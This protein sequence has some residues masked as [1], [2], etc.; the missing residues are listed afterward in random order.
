MIDLKPS[1]ERIEALVAQGTPASLTYAALECRLALERVCYDR[2]RQAHD[3]IAHDDLNGWSPGAIVKQL[4][5]DV[6]QNATTTM[7]LSISTRPADGNIRPE[8]QDYIKLGTHVGLDTKKTAR[9]WQALSNLALHSRL[10]VHRDDGLPDYGDPT[11]IA[12]KVSETLDELRRLSATKWIS[13]GMGHEA[14][15]TCRCGQFNKRRAAL[16]K[17]GQEVSCINAKCHWSW[18]VSVS[19]NE[20]E[21]QA[22]T[23]DTLCPDCGKKDGLPWRVLRSMKFQDEVTWNCAG[24]GHTNKVRLIFGQAT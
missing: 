10:P 7:T 8:D 4:V 19:G 24:C 11:A 21:F 20:F 23:I 12:A 15:F 14:S 22:M 1:I 2:L 13:S 9:L 3:Y 16:L 17:N 18:R 5:A 6:D